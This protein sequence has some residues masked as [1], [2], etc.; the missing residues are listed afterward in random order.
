M[1]N[2][3]TPSEPILMLPARADGKR[4]ETGP[5]QFGPDDWPGVF[6]RGDDAL[7]NANMLEQLQPLLTSEHW[8]AAAMLTGLIATLRSCKIGETG[9]PP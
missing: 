1:S 9:W 8:S 2:D 6:F 4:I 5:I 7:I 3:D